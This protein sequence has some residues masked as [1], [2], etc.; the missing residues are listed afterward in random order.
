MPAEFLPCV[1]ADGCVMHKPTA[2]VQAQKCLIAADG[3][4]E[5]SVSLADIRTRVSELRD[6]AS[7][8]R[9]ASL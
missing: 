3:A 5:P 2:C 8:A 4:I 7:E 6:L 9:S 1:A